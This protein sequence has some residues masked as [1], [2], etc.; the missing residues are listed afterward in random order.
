MGDP[1]PVDLRPALGLQRAAELALQLYGLTAAEISTLP[2]Y[3]DQ[4]FLI[5]DQEDKKFVL[6]VMNSEESKNVLRLELQTRA[7]SFL[8]RRGI[9]AP[10]AV[11]SA[12]GRLLNLEDMDF[13]RG[14][15]TFCVRLMNFLPGQTVA[16]S[17]VSARDLYHVGRLAAV[18]DTTLQQ[19][20]SPNLDVLQYEELW[21]LSN[22]PLL[23]DY[24]SVM[25]GDPLQDVI[26]AVIQQFKTHVMP[27]IV[28]FRKG[29]IHGD[30]SDQ[31]VLVAPAAGGR[32]E[33]SGLLDFSQL[34]TDCF[35]F[36]VAVMVAYMMLENRRP[37][38]AAAALLAGWESVLPLGE[39]EKD[40]LFLLVL[41]RLCQSL[42]YG[43]YNVTKYPDNR[44]YLLT[45]AGSGTR[46]L[47]E[48][49]QLGKKHVEEKWFTDAGTFSDT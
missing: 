31:N 10:T 29:L 3:M 45:T 41:G 46:L 38:D 34:R 26:T 24:L 20:V 12:A 27:K 18:V 40:A 7:M 13:G 39:E 35:V 30:M 37:L 21:S 9:P 47:H 33:V 25:D 42:V 2:S 19:F 5:V 44:K 14:A 8:K 4:N 48:L 28:S 36:E 22:V 6:K 17:P 23:E 1:L 16:A 11:L 43:R 32:L 49:W 15:Q